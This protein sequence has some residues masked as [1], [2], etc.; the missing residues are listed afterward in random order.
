MNTLFRLPG[1]GLTLWAATLL[2]TIGCSNP[3]VELGYVT[4]IIT[5]DGEPLDN[6]T[7]SFRPKAGGRP[8]FGLTDSNGYYTLYHTSKFAGAELGEHEV[9]I[10]L[11]PNSTYYA[12]ETLTPKMGPQLGDGSSV[13]V[14]GE[15]A[16]LTVAAGS[17]TYDFALTG[18]QLPKR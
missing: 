3:P 14:P 12:K 4:G 18:S 5:V 16:S 9:K 7:I 11:M 2:A 13:R 8:S 10:D 1:I 6:V 17:Q 15:M